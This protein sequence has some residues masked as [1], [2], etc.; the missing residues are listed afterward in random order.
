VTTFAS[1]VP[2]VVFRGSAWLVAGVFLL[3]FCSAVTA[4]GATVSGRGSVV[5]GP[6]SSTSGPGPTAT[7]SSSSTAAPA[8]GAILPAQMAGVWNGTYVCAQG[9]TAL[10]LTITVSQT[11]ELAAIFA[12]RA[13]AQNPTV[14][15]GSY[16]MI[17]VVAGRSL[18]FTPAGWIDQPAGYVQVG[19]DG[20]LPATTSPNR[21]AG[22]VVSAGCTDFSLTR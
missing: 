16:R 5:A 2:V 3:I 9:T 1:K 21:F 6:T 4:C 8:P 20:T 22:F 19:L 17:A 12:F 7:L 15:S 11:G 14:P 18:E 10:T 13:T